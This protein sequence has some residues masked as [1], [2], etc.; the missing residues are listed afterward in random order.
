M[1]AKKAGLAKP[2]LDA[3]LE[4]IKTY[5]LEEWDPVLAVKG[6]KVVLL[7]LKA[8]GDKAVQNES[9][10]ILGRI[11]KLDPVEGIRLGKG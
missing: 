3:I 5:Q 11:A 2:H 7:G 4:D 9:A 10:G 1:N 6:L 8:G